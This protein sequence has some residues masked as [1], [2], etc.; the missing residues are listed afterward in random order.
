MLTPTFH[1]SIL[2]TFFDT[3]VEHSEQLV[4]QLEK[5]E[6]KV[7]LTPIIADTALQILCGMNKSNLAHFQNEPIMA[8]Y[9]TPIKFRSYK[10][11]SKTNQ[12]NF[13]RYGTFLRCTNQ[14]SSILICFPYRN[15]DGNITEIGRC[16]TSSL[17]RCSLRVGSKEK[18]KK[19]TQFFFF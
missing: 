14:N 19:S 4:K 17:R 8:F 6:D 9:K 2:R 7:D 10:H 15:F 11:I 1:F 18:E 13:G 16:Q 3:M 5:C 12:S